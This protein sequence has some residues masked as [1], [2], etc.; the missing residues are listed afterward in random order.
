MI[1]ADSDLLVGF[2]RG[3]P[4]AAET[5]DRLEQED[6]LVTT[7]VNSFELLHG[8]LKSA[9]SGTNYPEARRIL[10]RIEVLPFE[11]RHSELAGKIY[12]DMLKKGSPISLSDLFIGSIALSS[13]IPVVT[14]NV[15]DFKRVPGLSV[16]PW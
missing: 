9:N 5:V 12:S 10:A 15:K 4:E 6:I 7:S 2:L 16:I 14:R 13:G 3:S 1:C 11:K 8:A